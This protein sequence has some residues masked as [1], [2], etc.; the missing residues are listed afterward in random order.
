MWGWRGWSD[1]SPTTF[2]DLF[3]GNHSTVSTTH[4]HYHINFT[5]ASSIEPTSAKPDSVSPSYA[6]LLLH[7]VA[8][9]LLVLK[10]VMKTSA[11]RRRPSTTDVFYWL[12]STILM[13]ST[14]RRWST[15]TSRKYQSGR[16]C[17]RPFFLMFS[18]RPKFEMHVRARFEVGR[19]IPNKFHTVNP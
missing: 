5:Q 16:P 15:S 6:I 1:R 14:G 13:F 17:L 18:S 19:N 11:L 9:Q 4:S 2:P 12:T 7:G 8:K 10:G 3:P